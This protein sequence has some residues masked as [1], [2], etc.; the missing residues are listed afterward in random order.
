M[1]HIDPPVHSVILEQNGYQVHPTRRT[2]EAIAA[3]KPETQFHDEFNMPVMNGK[4]SSR[5]SS[6]TDALKAFLFSFLPPK[7]RM[8]SA[9]GKGSRS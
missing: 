8:I 4:N 3:L 1:T 9:D 7:P 2:G 5:R 6:R